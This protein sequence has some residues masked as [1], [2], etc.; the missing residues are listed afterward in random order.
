MALSES[1]QQLASALHTGRY[2]AAAVTLAAFW[3]IESIAPMYL[4]RR[5]RLS[6]GLANLGIALINGAIA[7]GFAFIILYVTEYSRLHQ[8]GLL[9]HLE[10][11]PW[12]HWVLAII[13]FD[14]WQYWWHRLNHRVPFFWRFHAVHH[15][16]AEMDATSA[17]RFHTVEILLS[18]MVR[19]AVLPLL[20][21][22]IPQVLLYEA[23]SL[24]IIMFHHSNVRM[25]RGLDRVLRL[26][27]VTPWMHYVHHSRWQPETDSNYSSFLSIWD[28]LFGS[29]RLRDKPE[30][31]SLGL[32]GWEEG[33]WRSLWGML[34]SPFSRRG[35]GAAAAESAREERE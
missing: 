5:R 32:D 14:C 22:T 27:I 12:L 25:P 20:G 4:N 28:R 9:H 31:I 16:D 23:I 7:F 19:S 8:I 30:E 29:F 21:M 2:I 13:L 6:H 35:K 17:V 11:P 26:F 34:R 33:D 3:A 15:A 10:M 1:E 24:P 18:L